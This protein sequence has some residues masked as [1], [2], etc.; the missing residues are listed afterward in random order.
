M[1][2]K[3]PRRTF[4]AGSVRASV[5]DNE[6]VINGQKTNVPKVCVDRR[7]KNQEGEWLSSNHFSVN[8]L[9]KLQTVI[10]AAFDYLV[11]AGSED[12][13]IS[14]RDDREEKL[15]VK[16]SDHDKLETEVGK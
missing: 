14:L 4:R 8:E 7:Y 13:L 15:F 12:A 10:R 3:K 2:S 6:V 9:A 5:W 16:R 11:L 1:E